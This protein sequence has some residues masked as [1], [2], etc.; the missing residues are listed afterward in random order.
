VSDP[1]GET[2]CLG[3]GLLAAMVQGE[4]AGVHADRPAL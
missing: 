1:T 3:L 2:A 4:R